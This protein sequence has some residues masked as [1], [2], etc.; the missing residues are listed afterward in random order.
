MCVLSNNAKATTVAITD[1]TLY[2][3]MVSLSTQDNAKLLQQLK[4]GFKKTINWNKY[5]W[6]V[7]IQVSNPHLDYLIPSFQGVN[8]CFALSFENTTDRTIHRKY[9]L[10]TVEIEDYNVM[11][12]GQNFFDQLVKN[13]LRT[14]NNIKK[15]WLVKEMITWRVVH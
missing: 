15:L 4:S 6:K 9:Y 7:T 8:R 14:Y 10:P 11:I 3:L 5:Q 12:N 2:A 13:N 1:T